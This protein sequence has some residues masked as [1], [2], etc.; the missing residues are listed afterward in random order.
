MHL[1]WTRRL[2]VLIALAAVVVFVS[3]CSWLSSPPVSDSGRITIEGIAAT[4]LSDFEADVTVIVRS[5]GQGTF[6][7]LA[8]YTNYL[9]DHDNDPSTPPK[10]SYTLLKEDLGILIA[11][12]QVVS[13][14][15]TVK[16][17]Q[18]LRWIDVVVRVD[19]KT[20]ATARAYF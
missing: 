12:D 5:I 1:R 20:G 4:R 2:G 13:I 10:T 7:D 3:G 6:F 8:Y 18:T 11:N 19:G 15:T 14:R 9:I 16:A 17:E